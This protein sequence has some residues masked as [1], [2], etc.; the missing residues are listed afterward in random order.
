MSQANNFC[1][2]ATGKTH[3]FHISLSAGH[4]GFHDKEPLGSLY[5]LDQSVSI[6]LCAYYALLI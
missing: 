2:K 3:F 6:I 4:P 1:L 5:F